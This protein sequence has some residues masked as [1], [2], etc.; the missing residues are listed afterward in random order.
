MT[1]LGE[2]MMSSVK[3][4]MQILRMRWMLLLDH[5]LEKQDM[6]EWSVSIAIGYFRLSIRMRVLTLI[7]MHPGMAKEQ[8]REKKRM[9]LRLF[10]ACIAIVEM[11]RD[12]WYHTHTSV[13]IN[14]THRRSLEFNASFEEGLFP[15]AHF[16]VSDFTANGSANVTVYDNASGGGSTSGWWANMSW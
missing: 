16:N 1:F 2:A 6:E 13:K 8:S 3:S 15:P 5:T 9:P 11:S 7:L 10:L 14:W 12:T 4:V